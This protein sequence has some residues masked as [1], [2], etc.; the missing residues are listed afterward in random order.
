MDISQELQFHKPASALV[1]CYTFSLKIEGFVF[2]TMQNGQY[3]LQHT[4]DL[5]CMEL[6]M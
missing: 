4:C 3:V 5:Y 2:R 1:L 6:L